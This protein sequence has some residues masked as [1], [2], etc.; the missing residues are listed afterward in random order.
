LIPSSYSTRLRETASPVLLN[1]NEWM[2][3]ERF[4]N[5]GEEGFKGREGDGGKLS[6]T[7]QISKDRGDF[8]PGVS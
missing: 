7:E 6:F 5:G 3:A 1:I 2:T 4:K 8:V